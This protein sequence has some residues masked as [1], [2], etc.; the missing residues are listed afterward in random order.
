M[1]APHKITVPEATRQVLAST[2]Q[3][4][5][6]DYSLRMLWLAR[7]DKLG[8]GQKEHLEWLTRTFVPVGADFKAQACTMAFEG[9]DHYAL[10]RNAVA[11]YKA[12][13]ENK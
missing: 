13:L 9:Y 11:A 3:A 4:D 6:L 10:A 7:F 5:A 1:T 2:L 8:Y 12:A